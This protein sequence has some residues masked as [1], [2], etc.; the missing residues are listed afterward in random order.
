MICPHFRSQTT[1]T[2]VIWNDRCQVNNIRLFLSLCYLYRHAHA[3]KN[4]ENGHENGIMPPQKRQDAVSNVEEGWET[5]LWHT[6][7]PV[8]LTKMTGVSF[9][10]SPAVAVEDFD[11]MIAEI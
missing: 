11:M 6:A 3:Y 4:H 7:P 8:G 10:T 5:L 1:T 9:T 2:G